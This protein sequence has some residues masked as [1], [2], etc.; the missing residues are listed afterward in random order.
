MSD[1]LDGVAP[2]DLARARAR[3]ATFLG[4]VLLDG[5]TPEALAT[6]RSLPALAPSLPLNRSADELAARHHG[7]LQLGCPPYASLFLT[8]EAVLGGAPASAAAD[9]Y[10][11]AGFPEH[12]TDVEADH[13]GLQLRFWGFLTAAEADALRDGL[14]GQAVRLWTLR[15][16]FVRDHLGRWLPL[17]AQALSDEAAPEIAAVVELAM[18][19]VAPGT[20]LDPEDAAAWTLPDAPHPDALLDDPRTGLARI[21]EH[22]A[23][24]A[25]SGWWIGRGAI[26][27]WAAS[28]DVGRG[29]GER[30]RTLHV[31][32]AG[33]AE[34][35]RLSELLDHARRDAAAWDSALGEA[36]KLGFDTRPWTDRLSG[37][38]VLLDRM[39][40]AA[41]DARP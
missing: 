15:E 8:D 13:L 27:R 28:A 23:I 21:A 26:D 19:L 12:R 5:W 33:A 7:A 35:G 30:R 38:R 20:P 40:Q 31:A 37:T 14:P 16:G 41:A 9:A 6:A 36:R 25:R 2:A 18:A 17:M 39:A 4:H 11:A 32:L 1:P 34:R 24:P 10:Q 22:L 3:T 29:F